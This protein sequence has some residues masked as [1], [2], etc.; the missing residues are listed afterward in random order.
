[1][2]CLIYMYKQYH[3]LV[4]EFLI[5]DKYKKGANLFMP[6]NGKI[7]VGSIIAY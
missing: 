6:K 3:K 2:K 7:W 4:Y 5:G 1:M